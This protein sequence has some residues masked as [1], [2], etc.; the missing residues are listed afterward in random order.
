MKNRNRDVDWC[1]RCGHVVMPN[2]GLFEKRSGRWQLICFICN[3]R[4]HAKIK[5]EAL[6]GF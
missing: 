3:G 1:A 6:K 5:S 2:K 4:K